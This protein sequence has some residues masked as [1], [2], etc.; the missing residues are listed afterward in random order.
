MELLGIEQLKGYSMQSVEFIRIKIPP[1]KD[2]KKLFYRLLEMA[3]IDK[4]DFL[5]VM[6]PQMLDQLKTEKMMYD[7][8]KEN[9]NVEDKR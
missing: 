1:E 9:K 5:I 2:E 6:T 4:A 7:K 8:M 3:R